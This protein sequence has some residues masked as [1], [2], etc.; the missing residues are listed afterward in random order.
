MNINR[1]ENGPVITPDH[2]PSK[3][4]ALT[5]RQSPSLTIY[6]DNC[7]GTNCKRLNDVSVGLRE[8]QH[9]GIPVCA[10]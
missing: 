1:N 2:S 4:P 3:F 6:H 8:G 5:G 7:A 9:H 10:R